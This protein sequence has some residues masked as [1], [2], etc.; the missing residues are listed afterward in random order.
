MTS[1]RSE[2]WSP[3]LRRAWT[4]AAYARRFALI[5][6]RSEFLASGA[7][8]RARHALAEAPPGPVTLFDAA[9]MIGSTELDRLCGY[10]V[11]VLS[12]PRG[13]SIAV[14]LDVLG[15]LDA[16]RLS[17][18][19]FALPSERRKAVRRD[20]VWAYLVQQV[21]REIPDAQERLRELIDSTPTS[22]LGYSLARAGD[23]V[24]QVAV[25]GLRVGASRDHCRDGLCRWLQ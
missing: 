16:D 13:R 9:Q 10:A 15:V 1:A 22:E 14:L 4:I 5:A 12:D 20:P 11:A 24:R 7:D 2:L 19:Y 23:S 8:D 3:E 21:E 6:R 18:V 17:A 25:P